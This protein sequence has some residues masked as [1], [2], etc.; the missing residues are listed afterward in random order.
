MRKANIFLITIYLLCSCSKTEKGPIIEEQC[1][2]VIDF[3]G[4]PTFSLVLVDL[5]GNNLI[6]NG[7]F[8]K[9]EIS[10]TMNGVI[11]ENDIVKSDSVRLHPISFLTDAEVV[12]TNYR[13]LLKLSNTDTDTL[14]YFL[15]FDE[16]KDRVEDKLF[17][18][19]LVKLDSAR[20]NN[21]KITWD[22]DFEKSRYII[23]FK[24]VKAV[25]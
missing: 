18:G 14:D 4:P 25:N 21:V 22:I 13:W 5:K 9:D 17:C 19:T 15:S 12:E 7:F 1:A 8:K 23:P 20:Y 16:V 3:V 11:T 6:E 10:A 2:G 24:V